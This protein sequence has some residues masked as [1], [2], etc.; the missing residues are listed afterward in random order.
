MRTDTVPPVSRHVLITGATGGIGAAIARLLAQRGTRLTFVARDPGRLD[1]LVRATAQSGESVLPIEADLTD[2]EKIGAVAAEAVRLHGPVDVLINNAAVNGFGHLEDTAPAE[3]QRVLTTNLMAPI[4]LTRAVVPDMIA[5]RDGQIVNVGSIFGSIGFAGFAAYSSGKFALRGFSEALRRELG[6]SGV[7]VTYVAPRYTKTGLNSPA[8]NRLAEA[9]G[10][11][12][13][14]PAEVA[15]QI[16]SAIE[17]RKAELII[18]RAER[19]FVRLNALWPRLVDRGLAKT[20]QIIRD[21]AK[22]AA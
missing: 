16:V 4:L 6:D 21:I 18:G 3:I 5:R 9:T 14:D 1:D 19:V 7:T 15:R 22:P 13:D 20:T 12:M 2:L 10:M 11:A 8:V 17:R